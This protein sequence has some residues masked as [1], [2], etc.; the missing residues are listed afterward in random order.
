MRRRRVEAA[1]ALAIKIQ[2]TIIARNSSNLCN[3]DNVKELWEKVRQAS[4]T[5]KSAPGSNTTITAE[6]LNDHYSNVSTDPN[7]QGSH[8]E[9]YDPST[10][11]FFLGNAD[12]PPAWSPEANLCRDW[13]VSVLVFENRCPNFIKAAHNP[14]L[15]CLCPG[16]WYQ[17]SGKPVWS[18]RWPTFR[19]VP[20]AQITALISVTPILSR[21]LEKLKLVVLKFLYPIFDHPTFA[22]SF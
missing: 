16:P 6:M 22:P 5:G 15:I 19:A 17:I 4:G 3:I 18:R 9:V 11:S 21:V 10:Q 12:F 8:V 14:V 1:N 13:W 20:L 7:Y 2:R